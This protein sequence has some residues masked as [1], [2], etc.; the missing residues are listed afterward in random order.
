MTSL[1][2]EPCFLCDEI[3]ILKTT[4]IRGF[5]SVWITT[6]EILKLVREVVDDKHSV[7]FS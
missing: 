2:Q 5:C 1:E 3:P 6:V 4:W 7:R